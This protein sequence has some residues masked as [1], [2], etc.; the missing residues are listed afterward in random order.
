MNQQ[1]HTKRK[2]ILSG[3]QVEGY[4]CND[5]KVDIL[6]VLTDRQSMNGNFSATVTP[7]SLSPMYRTSWRRSIVSGT[8]EEDVLDR[9][10]KA[11]RTAV[12]ETVMRED[13]EGYLLKDGQQ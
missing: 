2:A 5:G 10:L 7:H 9:Y 13:L 4:L 1:T 8:S 6:V 3:Q 11:Q 12:R